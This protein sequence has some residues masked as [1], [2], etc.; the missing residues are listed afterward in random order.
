MGSSIIILFAFC[1]VVG[2][3]LSLAR[4]VNNDKENREL[5]GIQ[6][7]FA[8]QIVPGKNSKIEIKIKV[9]VSILGF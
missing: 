7:R 3:F 2:P 4:T 8:R 9:H 1:F 5:D 6:R